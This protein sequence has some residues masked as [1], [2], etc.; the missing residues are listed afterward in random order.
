MEHIDKKDSDEGTMAV[1]L[2][3]VSHQVPNLLALKDRIDGGDTLSRV[4]IAN[5]EEIFERARH[6]IHFYDEHPEVQD[7]VA[8]VVSIY[9]HITTKALENEEAGGK[10]PEINLDD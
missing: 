9:L 3:R 5:L 8:Q 7:L 10:P 4:E 1:M 2:E 6:M